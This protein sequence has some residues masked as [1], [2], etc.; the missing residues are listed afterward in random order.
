[1]R[2]VENVECRKCG[3][4]KCGVWKMISVEYAEFENEEY[5]KCG[6]R[7]WLFEKWITLSTC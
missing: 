2:R 3:V 4:G 5:R 7:P 1:M 6:V